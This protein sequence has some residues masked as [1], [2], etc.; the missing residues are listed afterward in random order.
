MDLLNI[1]LKDLLHTISCA[2]IQH[3][4]QHQQF[5]QQQQNKNT[6]YLTPNTNAN[7]LLTTTGPVIANTNQHHNN[8]T[9]TT[10]LIFKLEELLNTLINVSIYKMKCHR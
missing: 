5:L 2:H 9:Y 1:H 4:Q 3:I 10:Q 7:L 8:S 6:S